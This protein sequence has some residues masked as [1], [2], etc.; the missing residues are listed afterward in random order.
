[1]FLF[2]GKRIGGPAYP[3][4]KVLFTNVIADGVNIGDVVRTIDWW[5]DPA[6]RVQHG[7]IE[8]AD[9][10]RPDPHLYDSTENPDGTWTSVPRDPSVIA[11]EDAAAA[12]AVQDLADAQAAKGYAKLRALATMTPA[13]IQTWCDNNITTTAAERD[14]IKTLAV[15][16]GVLARRL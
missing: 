2:E 16:V 4:G 6:H 13:Q 11:A 14:A 9:I 8:A 12:Q 5:I 10:P 15:A 3:D 7:V 1:M